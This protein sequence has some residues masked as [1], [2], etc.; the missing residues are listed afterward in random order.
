MLLYPRCSSLCVRSFFLLPRASLF[1]KQNRL[2]SLLLPKHIHSLIL[3]PTIDER[4][5]E[6][7]LKMTAVAKRNGNV[8]N[9]NVVTYILMDNVIY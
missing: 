8:S 9:C 7:S 1:L 4:R 2:Y 6:E 5:F 3:I